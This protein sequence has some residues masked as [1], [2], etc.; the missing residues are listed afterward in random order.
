MILFCKFF[1][2]DV[3]FI[4]FYH[5]RLIVIQSLFSCVIKDLLI[6]L[7]HDVLFFVRNRKNISL[8]ICCPCGGD[9]KS[10]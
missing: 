2:S 4:S 6:A 3:A 7:A 8:L 1:L 9:E 10:E 5:G